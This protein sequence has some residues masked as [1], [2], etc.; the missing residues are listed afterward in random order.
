[1]LTLAVP[2]LGDERRNRLLDEAI[3]EMAHRFARFAEEE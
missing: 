3:V 1:M 2:D